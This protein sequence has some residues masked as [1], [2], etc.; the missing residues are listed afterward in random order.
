MLQI[1]LFDGEVGWGS[2]RI[3][4]ETRDLIR[5]FDRL[6]IVDQNPGMI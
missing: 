1:F 2:A 4:E 5:M 6:Y 3:D